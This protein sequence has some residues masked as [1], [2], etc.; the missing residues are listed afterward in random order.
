MGSSQ[1]LLVGMAVR[2]HAMNDSAS[3]QVEAVQM[4]YHVMRSVEAIYE[5]VSKRIQI[6][7]QYKSTAYGTVCCTMLTQV[8]SSYQGRKATTE[9]G[10]NVVE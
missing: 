7:P 10:S 1:E 8:S 5:K 3:P 4:R 9:L 2:K 6:Q